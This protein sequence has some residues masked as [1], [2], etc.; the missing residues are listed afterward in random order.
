MVKLKNSCSVSLCREFTAASN[1]KRG[2]E[3]S[4]LINFTSFSIYI[5]AAWI[6]WNEGVDDGNVKVHIRKP[7]CAVIA[8][9]GAAFS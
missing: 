3:S 9:M 1:G 4:Y 2:N 6:Y 8:P 5:S 7:E